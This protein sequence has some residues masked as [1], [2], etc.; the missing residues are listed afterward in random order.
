MDFKFPSE[1][2]DKRELFD[3]EMAHLGPEELIQIGDEIVEKTIDLNPSIPVNLEIQKTVEHKRVMNSS[4]KDE[5]F[6]STFLNISLTGLFKGSKEGVNR[7]YSSGKLIPFPEYKIK[8]MVKEYE[9][10]ENFCS[11]PTKK[12]PVIFT[13]R[14]MW[15]LFYRL[16]EG[17]S[18]PNIIRGTSPLTKKLGEKIFPETFNILDDPTLE[19][20]PHSSPIDDEGVPTKKKYIIEK[21]V[22]KNFLFDLSTGAKHGT[23]STG[24][25]FKRSLFTS[26]IS[27][28]PSPNLTTL[29][30]E[31]GEHGYMDMIASMDEGIIADYLVGAHSGNVLHG[32]LSANIGIGFYVK[33]GQIAGRAM[34][35][36][37]AGNI[38]DFFHNIKLIGNSPILDSFNH[39]QYCPPLLFEDISI[40]GAG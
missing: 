1:N 25:G 26:S 15:A 12:M 16:K 34:D 11:I 28:S 17:I 31:P 13:P 2:G 10:S 14:A 19:F 38:Y 18:G 30:V 20:F 36:M 32:D 7:S 22:L 9:L 40:S 39:S 5:Q 21:G 4:G 8:S 37:L 35:S 23:G 27:M 3:P 6:Q 29:V 24:N 33:D